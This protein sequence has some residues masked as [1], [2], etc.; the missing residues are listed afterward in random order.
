MT[1]T[2]CPACAAKLPER[3]REMSNCLYCG[4]PFEFSEAA[5]QGGADGASESPYRARIERILEHDEYASSIAWEPPHGAD[6]HQAK[7][8]QRLGIGL[9]LG[10]GLALVLGLS[11]GLSWGWLFVALLLAGGGG[12]LI[13]RAQ[14]ELAAE[15]RWPV[16]QRACAIVD[17]RSETEPRLLE[18]RTNYHFL[19]EFEDGQR[20]EFRWPGRGTSQEPLS[21]GITGIAYTRGKTLVNFKQIRN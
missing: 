14:R 12:A 8:R 21:T 6:Y 20:A 2:H 1:R 19:L 16:L 18:G 10:A 15:T 11:G 7:R 5:S 9:L 4:F 17:R 13:A 3:S